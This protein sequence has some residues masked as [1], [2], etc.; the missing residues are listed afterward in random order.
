MAFFT[1]HII[2]CIQSA[3]AAKIVEYTNQTKVERRTYIVPVRSA[4]LECST[5][6]CALVVE[7][8]V[9]DDVVKGVTA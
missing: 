9:E 2:L 5:S 4:H 7:V 1:I 8:A 6:S 3:H